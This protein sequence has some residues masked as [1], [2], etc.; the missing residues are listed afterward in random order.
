[1]RWSALRATVSLETASLASNRGAKA[2]E[3]TIPFGNS[4]VPNIEGCMGWPWLP[5]W[6]FYKRGLPPNVVPVADQ[7]M[8]SSYSSVLASI[9]EIHEAL[10]R[11]DI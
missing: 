4:N 7:V 6:V 8:W 10:C 2:R 9:L 5:Q 11:A 3:P 1:M